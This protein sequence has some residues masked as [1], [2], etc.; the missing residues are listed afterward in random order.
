MSQGTRE[1][2]ITKLLRRIKKKKNNRR[3]CNQE[4]CAFQQEEGLGGESEEAP[5]KKKTKEK[6]AGGKP[7]K[8]NGKRRTPIENT[9]GQ[10]TTRGSIV[11]GN[12][13]MRTWGGTF[14]AGLRSTMTPG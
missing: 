4:D 5:R 1:R 7:L 11:S 6:P 3:L 13:D 10:W 9:G 12:A 14:W 2:G 8:V